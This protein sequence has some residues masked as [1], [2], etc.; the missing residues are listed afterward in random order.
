VSSL[1]V[2]LD[3]TPLLGTRTGVATFCAGALSGLGRREDLV[4]GG[5]AV[6]WRRRRG[7]AGQ[8]PPGVA[9]VGRAMPARPLHL[10]WRWLGA[11][12]VE[13]FVGEADVVHGTN[14]VVPPARR[15]AL[16]VTVHD[17]TAIRFPQMCEPA[18]LA[19]PAQVRRAISRGAWLH[20]PSEWVAGEVVDHFGV[21]PARV[22][23]V[24]H[25]AALPGQLPLDRP[26]GADLPAEAG[27]V[28]MVLPVPVALPAAVERYVLALGTIEPRKDLVGLVRAFDQLAGDR[29]DVALVI[30]GADGWGSVALDEA[31]ADSAHRKRIVRLGFVSPGVRDSLLARAAVL[32]YPSIYEGFG[33]PPLEAMARGVP[34]VATQAGAL[35]EVLGDGAE[36]VA[37]G[38]PDALAGALARLLDDKVA[39]A[40]LGRRGKRR[41][42]GFSWERCAEGLVGLYRDAV[43]SKSG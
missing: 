22:R 36:L 3:A 18:S 41:A 23:A 32:A 17:L 30:A 27:P 8:L 40:A 25:G 15:A 39:S 20:T 43:A 24:H 42:A 19:F 31:V 12:P 7:I 37:V 16:V 21:D 38:D 1:R 2:V 35:V 34:V 26:A 13:W 9:A 11:P 33:L 29:P 4:V 6:S 14:F 28:S 10:A 5:Y